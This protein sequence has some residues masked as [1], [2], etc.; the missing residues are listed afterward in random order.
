VAIRLDV[1]LQR[2]RL[3]AGLLE[4]RAALCNW[5]GH[6]VEHHGPHA[7][8]K[9]TEVR[10]VSDSITCLRRASYLT[11]SYI[12]RTAGGL[13]LVD[14]G[15][16][17]DADDVHVG[18]Q[19]LGAD[20]S[21]IRAILLTHWHND[22]AAGAQAIHSASGAPVY[23]HRADAR[24]FTGETA[25]TGLRRWLSDRIP[26]MGVLVLAKGLLGESTPRPV[27][28]Q[29]FVSDGE[30]LLDDFEVIATPGHTA[31]HVSYFY[32]PDRALFAGDALAVIGGRIRFMA[33]PVTLDVD[34][35]RRS[36]AECLARSPEIV[37]PGHR[38]PLVDARPA[39]E[40]MRAY[41]AAG[42][43]WPLLG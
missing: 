35:A 24:Y 39:C 25:T 26:E 15:M 13:V 22:H 3:V 14:A 33:R 19:A 41:L 21:E 43:T 17:S 2:P 32:R 7:M 34:A 20:A 31:G 37:C 27:S 40:R 28:A 6:D 5:D 30:I 11:C 16:D 36:L 1:R 23:Y 38:E 4:L 42:G 12:V 10:R 9:S 8:V 29:H 18:L